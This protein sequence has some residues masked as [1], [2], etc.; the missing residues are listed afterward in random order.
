MT[1]AFRYPSDML[2]PYPEDA[3]DAVKLAREGLLFVHHVDPL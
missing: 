2:E 3:E 1:V